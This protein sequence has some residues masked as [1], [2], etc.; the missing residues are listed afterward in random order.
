VSYG[1]QVDEFVL[2]INRAAERAALQ[3]K[4]IFWDAIGEMT[5]DDA[6]KILD[7]GS[8]GAGTRR[9]ETRMWDRGQACNVQLRSLF[10]SWQ[11]GGCRPSPRL[12]PSGEMI[13]R[14]RCGKT[15]SSSNP[16]AQGR[17]R[18]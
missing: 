15:T 3:A 8:E 10:V 18:G 1:P 9:R 13:F 5:F 2:S 14:P 11:R 4:Q 6:R 7:E 12:L 17:F 16:T